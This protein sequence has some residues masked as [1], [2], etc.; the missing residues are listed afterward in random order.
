[1]VCEFILI[2]KVKEHAVLFIIECGL[3]KLNHL[4]ISMMVDWSVNSRIST[5]LSLKAPIRKI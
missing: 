2:L 5:G 1:M 3:S 4:M